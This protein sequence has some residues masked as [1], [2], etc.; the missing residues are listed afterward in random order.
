MREELIEIGSADILI[1]DFQPQ[2][3]WDMSVV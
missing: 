3:L 1:M 2:E